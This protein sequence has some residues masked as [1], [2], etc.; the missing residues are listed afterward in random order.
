M[1]QSGARRDPDCD[2]GFQVDEISENLPKVTVI[3][4]LKL[5]FDNDL[6]AVTVLP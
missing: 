2:V 5:I 6:V 3:C 4:L 1:R